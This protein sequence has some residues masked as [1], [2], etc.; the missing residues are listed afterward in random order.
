MNQELGDQ[1][2]VE[3]ALAAGSARR[4]AADFEESRLDA[5]ER[6]EPVPEGLETLAADLLGIDDPVRMYFREIGRVALLTA[7]EE[8]VLAKAIEL[9]EELVEAPWT[10]VLRLWE[11]TRNDTER[12]TRTLHP[13]HRLPYGRESARIVREAFRQADADGLLG[14]VPDL[15]LVKAQREATGQGT[16]TLLKEAK[17]RVGAYNEGPTTDAFTDLVDFAFRSVHNGDL[18]AR[19]NPGPAR[20]L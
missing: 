19:D 2:L 7:E 16:K 10:G 13:Q 8:V 15:H 5:R 14:Q 11:W 1:Q 17:S 18:D 9:G 12:K 4:H 20:A 3:V 6:A